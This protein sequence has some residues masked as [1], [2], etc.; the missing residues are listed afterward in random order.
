MTNSQSVEQD[1]IVAGNIFA[2]LDNANR[3]VNRM[4][5]ITLATSHMDLSCHLSKHK[6]ENNAFARKSQIP[7]RASS[8]LFVQHGLTTVLKLVSWSLVRRLLV[9]CAFGTLCHWRAT[10]ERVNK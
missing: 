3:G 2:M 10:K 8:E 6:L 1:G 7:F 9:I 4:N 5:F